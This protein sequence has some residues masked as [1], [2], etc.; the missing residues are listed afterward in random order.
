MFIARYSLKTWDRVHK[1][2]YI[3][4]TFNNS[5]IQIKNM[6]K[7]I[8]NAV[9]EHQKQL[10][11]NVKFAI[12]TMETTT[13]LDEQD[14]IDMDD[15]SRQSDLQEDKMKMQEKLT[16]EQNE[17]RYV[18]NFLVIDAMEEFDKGAVVETD[19]AY[20]LIGFAFSPIQHKDKKIFGISA[21]APAFQSNI[22]KK[23]GDTLQLG[24][25]THKIQ[26]IY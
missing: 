20:F 18:R 17:L 1:Y 15:L 11:E 9:I 3:L 14:T 13:D 12:D 22:G 23:Q 4:C 25:V 21:N 8:I 16:M 10:I 26:H 5:K 19:K 6:R 7:E 24:E 2:L